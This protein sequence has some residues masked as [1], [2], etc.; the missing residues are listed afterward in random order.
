[1]VSVE[2]STAGQTSRTPSSA[3]RFR[4]LPPATIRMMF[5]ST[6][7]ELSIVMPIANATPAIEITLM[8]RPVINRPRKAASTQ[9]GIPIEP[10]SVADQERRNS[11]RTNTASTAPI[12]RFWMTVRTES[13]MYITSFMRSSTTTP[14]SRAIP[15][16]S[17]AIAVPTSSNTCTMLAPTCFLI[18]MNICGWPFA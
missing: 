2:A 16:F 11:R 4:S 17:S 14:Y 7:I 12:S 18:D 10:I 15:S 5:S 6:T 9:T 1:M 13:R 3:A 8:V